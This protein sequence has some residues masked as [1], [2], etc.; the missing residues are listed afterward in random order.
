M[1]KY[2]FALAITLFITAVVIQSFGTL[3]PDVSFLLHITQKMLHGG[4]YYYNFFEINPPLI[5]YLYTPPVVIA[6]LLHCGF[7]IPIRTY[8]FAIAAGSL[9][10]CNW[11]L[12]KI[13]AQ[14]N[15]YSHG[16]L[17]LAI[18]FAFVLMPGM[19]FGQREHI[20]IMLV[21]PYFLLV[22]LRLTG[23]SLEIWQL[24]FIGILA[25]IGFALKPYFFIPLALVELYF[26]LKKGKFWAW[27]R[28]EI[29]MIGLVSIIYLATIFLFF[30]EY[31]DKMVPIGWKLFYAAYHV[32]WLWVLTQVPIAFFCIVIILLGFSYKKIQ[33]LQLAYVLLIASIGFFVCDIIQQTIFYYHILPL[34]T[35]SMMLLVL[36]WQPKQYQSYKYRGVILYS[37]IVAL[38]LF[39]IAITYCKSR[40]TIAVKYQNVLPFAKLIN[41]YAK[42]GSI[43]CFSIYIS[44]AYPVIDYAKVTTTSRFPSFWPLRGIKRQSTDKKYQRMFVNNVIQDLQKQPPSLI[45][46]GTKPNPY[47]IP[48]PGFNYLTF[49]G[50][51]PRFNEIFKHYHY[52][53][54]FFSFAIYQR[55][56]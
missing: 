23:K 32:P 47:F 2:F 5:L 29:A 35:T 43:Y 39:P 50:K 3:S 7:F 11:L 22:S 27:L 33:Q 16:P 38:L 8:V 1:R 18:T 17:L 56:T 37:I 28:P 30:P 45:I 4:R 48:I 12:R 9:I 52:R 21:V 49:F 13:F 6:H 14:E 53:E 44:T 34:F 25:G 46:I 41:K 40:E 55:E 24:V 15:N 42:H 54:T 31:I 19:Q 10:L 36:L 51:D 26:L 20:M